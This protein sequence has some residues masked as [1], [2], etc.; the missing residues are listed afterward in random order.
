MAEPENK[1]QKLYDRIRP[2]RIS[3]PNKATL[4]LYGYTGP[5]HGPGSVRKALAWLQDQ[6]ADEEALRNAFKGEFALPDW[7]GY[8]EWKD[9]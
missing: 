8:E 4:K 9:D 3:K 7:A 2:A 1:F 5:D 6:A